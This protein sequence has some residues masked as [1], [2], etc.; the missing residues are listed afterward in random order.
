[1]PPPL[2]RIED[3]FW[4]LRPGIKAG[5]GPRPK[6]VLTVEVSQMVRVF[7]MPRPR[8]ALPSALD[9][10]RVLRESSRGFDLEG[11]RMWQ[12][13]RLPYFIRVHPRPSVVTLKNLITSALEKGR[14]FRSHL[15]QCFIPAGRLVVSAPG[16]MQ[17]RA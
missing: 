2:A 9:L 1:M 17:L 15:R 5:C 7:G 3:K 4:N 16:M 6:K 8:T 13:R 11:R 10:P 12:A 14:I